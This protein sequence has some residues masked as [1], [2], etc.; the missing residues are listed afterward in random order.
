MV[1]LYFRK[2]LWFFAYI[3]VYFFMSYIISMFLGM[4]LGP[5]ILSILSIIGITVWVVATTSRRRYRDGDEKRGYLQECGEKNEFKWLG[6]LKSV[7]RTAQFKAEFLSFITFNAVL[8]IVV[9]AGADKSSVPGLIFGSL[10]TICLFTGG[11]SAVDI[12]VW[13]AVRH[14][15]YSEKLFNGEEK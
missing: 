10:V 9:A 4:F 11:F 2:V 12:A 1:R 8:I 14:K 3:V 7:L 5:G 13:L 15:W 6:E